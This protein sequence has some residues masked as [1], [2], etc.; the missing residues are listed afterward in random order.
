[1]D[2]EVFGREGIKRHF[3]LPHV[4]LLM[5][6]TRDRLLLIVPSFLWGCGACYGR[7]AQ[8]DFCVCAS[9]HICVCVLDFF[10]SGIVG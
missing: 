6:P 7:H 2:S 3:T 9:M 4:Q 10:A 8:G 5:R 1:M